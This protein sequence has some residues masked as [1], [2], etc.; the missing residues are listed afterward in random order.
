MTIN[1][2]QYQDSGTLTSGRGA[3]TT[4]IANI[5][6]MT[7]GAAEA[8]QYPVYP[9]IR[10]ASAPLASSYEYF[11]FFKLSGTYA[12]GSRVRIQISGNVNGANADGYTTVGTGARLYYRL[13]DTYYTPDATDN[14]DLVFY[15]GTTV[16]LF[17]K[18]SITGPTTDLNYVQHLTADT[19]YYTQ[20]LILRLLVEQGSTYGN[21]GDLAI[22][23][24]VDEYESA[25]L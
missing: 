19:T 12:A 24:Y 22:Q 2:D 25:D 16:T 6:L 7:N 10:P 21:I 14:G 23:C 13:S 5:G 15:N 17:P 20:Y 8:T 18:I 4:L 1:I 11:T 3:T 9:I